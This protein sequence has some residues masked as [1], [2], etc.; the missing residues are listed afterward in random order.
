M[1]ARSVAI[2][3]V[4]VATLFAGVCGVHELVSS[5]RKQQEMLASSKHICDNS[6]DSGGVPAVKNLTP[7]SQVGLES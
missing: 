4:I 2:A 6:A 1:L 3:H 5:G 7:D